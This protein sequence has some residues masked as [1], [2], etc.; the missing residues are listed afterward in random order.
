MRIAG[1]MSV[2]ELQVKE[3]LSKAS[4]IT[5]D[6]KLDALYQSIEKT[7]SKLRVLKQIDP[8]GTKLP[9]QTIA[10]RKFD[11]AIA[12]AMAG[13]RKR[14]L[15]LGAQGAVSTL[16]GG[17][18]RKDRIINDVLVDMMQNSDHPVWKELLDEEQYSVI[19]A[20]GKMGV[21]S[22]SRGGQSGTPE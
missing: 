4:G 18:G 6:A 3:A 7:R 20:L 1:D 21:F 16:T 8:S 15:Y 22:T 10:E 9:N 2:P 13:L 17:G 19:K 14:A 12:S 11:E 5:D